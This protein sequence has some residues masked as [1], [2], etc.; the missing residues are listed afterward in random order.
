MPDNKKVKLSKAKAECFE[1]IAEEHGF[2]TQH[3]KSFNGD[4]ENMNPY[5]NTPTAFAYL[6]YCMA[7]DK[8][9]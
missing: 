4:Y 5:W 8:F 9:N 7:V 6:G 3:D 2:D 1:V